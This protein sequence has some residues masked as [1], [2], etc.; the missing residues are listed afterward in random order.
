M[1]KRLFNFSNYDIIKYTAN[2]FCICDLDLWPS[3]LEVL[4][5]NRAFKSMCLSKKFDWNLIHSLWVMAKKKTFPPL[6]TIKWFTSGFTNGRTDRQKFW[7]ET[8]IHFKNITYR[9]ALHIH[10]PLKAKNLAYISWFKNTTRLA[11][12]DVSEGG[13]GSITTFPDFE[14]GLSK[15]KFGIVFAETTN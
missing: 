7:Q 5:Q 3:N 14:N 6:T 10:T 1:C 11:L 9:E 12:L 13:R 2:H 8:D 4:H 15:L